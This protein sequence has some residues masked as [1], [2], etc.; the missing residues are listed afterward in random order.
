L[1][2]IR[3]ES[4]ITMSK[5]PLFVNYYSCIANGSLFVQS[6]LMANN[7]DKSVFN[8]NS[9]VDVYEVKDGHY[10]F[11]FYIPDFQGNKVKSFRVFGDNLFIIYDHYISA[12]RISFP[13]L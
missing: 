13:N 10:R 5:P 8:R 12:Y 2:E 3:S 6:A 11:S 4:S 9:V 1:G 7:E